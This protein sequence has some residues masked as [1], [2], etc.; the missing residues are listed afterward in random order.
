[1]EHHKVLLVEESGLVSVMV[2]QIF[3][4]R[5]PSLDVTWVET[6]AEAKGQVVLGA[7]GCPNYSCIILDLHLPNSTGLDTIRS[8]RAL[9]RDIPLVVYTAQV[10]QP[11]R[12]YFD[13]GADDYVS[14]A[15]PIRQLEAAVLAA[16]KRVNKKGEHD[17]KW[18][19]LSRGV[20]I[21]ER[22]T[23]ELVNQRWYDSEGSL[24]VVGER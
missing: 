13:A 23:T 12:N 20:R 6:L 15:A 2:R 7:G 4:G 1:M 19:A 17:R 16:I 24:R 8:I 10:D 9:C 18:L 21:L 3:E 11:V 14:K 5:G 22:G